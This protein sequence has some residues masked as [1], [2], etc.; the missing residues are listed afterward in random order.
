MQE[1]IPFVLK[2]IFCFIECL[3][4]LLL[5][6]QAFTTGIRGRRRTTVDTR[7]AESYL[8]TSPFLQPSCAIGFYRMLSRSLYQRR[9]D[10]CAQSG[11]T[12]SALFPNVSGSTR[13]TATINIGVGAPTLHFAFSTRVKAAQRS[14]LKH[15]LFFFEHP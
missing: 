3:D 14:D 1:Q 13:Q 12:G 15:L 11:A 2:V 9:D 7:S 10:R 8:L 5:N 4:E 6:H